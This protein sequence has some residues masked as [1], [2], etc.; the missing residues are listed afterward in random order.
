MKPQNCDKTWSYVKKTLIFLALIIGTMCTTFVAENVFEFILNQI[1]F[2][3]KGIVADSYASALQQSFGDAVLPTW[4]INLKTIGR[5]GLNMNYKVIIYFISLSI[6]IGILK[7]ISLCCCKK[8]IDEVIEKIESAQPSDEKVDFEPLPSLNVI[9]EKSRQ[10][11]SGKKFVKSVKDSKESLIKKDDT[12]GAE[13][14]DSVL[15]VDRKGSEAATKSVEI[16]TNMAL[17]INSF[18]FGKHINLKNDRFRLKNLF[19]RGQGSKQLDSQFEDLTKKLANVTNENQ[20]SSNES[21][22]SEIENLQHK[23]DSNA[24]DVESQVKQ[25]NEVKVIAIVEPKV[26]TLKDQ[27]EEKEAFFE[28]QTQSNKEIDSKLQTALENVSKYEDKI[29]TL[30]KDLSKQREEI[31]SVTI[32]KNNII[33]EHIKRIKVL[34]DQKFNDDMSLAKINDTVKIL[35]SQLSERDSEIAQL[36]I[37]IQK[38]GVK[39]DTLEKELKTKTSLIDNLEQNNAEMMSTI[40]ALQ[41]QIENLNQAKETRES[42]IQDLFAKAEQKDEQKLYDDKMIE[43]ASNDIDALIQVIKKRQPLGTF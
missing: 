16:L 6:N 2:G 17:P 12:E 33:E 31:R 38:K 41:E 42:K 8:E 4:F 28:D 24:E 27:I 1:G 14:V 35:Q 18:D 9:K 26:E 10:I 21:L 37:L 40:Q 20:T 43:K 19:G 22:K 29:A 32:N 13:L 15:N 25:K 3:E 7:L 39:I 23:F 30:E 36:G 11:K 5:K 34:E